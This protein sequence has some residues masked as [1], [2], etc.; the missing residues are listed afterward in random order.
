MFLINEDY[1]SQNCAVC[2]HKVTHPGM[3]YLDPKHSDLEPLKKRLYK[4]VG[5]QHTGFCHAVRHRDRNAAENIATLFLQ[6]F[7]GSAR[8]A[9]FERKFVGQKI[10]MA[11]SS[12]EGEPKMT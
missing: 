3:C 4:M 8:P 2:H 9:A 12:S 1:T 5:C 10:V 7:L 11:A 6:Q